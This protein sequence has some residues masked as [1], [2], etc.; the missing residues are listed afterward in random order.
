MLCMSQQISDF[1]ILCTY[2]NGS[3]TCLV[4]YP[5]NSCSYQ[6]CC[7]VVIPAQVDSVCRP[8][9]TNRNWIMR[10]TYIPIRSQV[11]WGL[12]YSLLSWR[13]VLM[14]MIYLATEWKICT[15]GKV[16]GSGDMS[17]DVCPENSKYREII[18]GFKPQISNG[19]A[20][21]RKNTFSPLQI[22][23]MRRKDRDPTLK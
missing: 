2:T 7:C 22:P 19:R 14:Y 1:I 11:F 18:D 9:S 17:C 8:N 21:W 10:W 15:P 4:Y 16:Q 20:W 13:K 6:C 23:F 12:G 5:Q 3:L